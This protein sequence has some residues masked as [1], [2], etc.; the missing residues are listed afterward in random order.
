MFDFCFQLC[1]NV[2]N[3]KNKNRGMFMRDEIKNALE[4]IRSKVLM[5]L[6]AIDNEEVDSKY[7]LIIFREERGIIED[8]IDDIE[9]A[10]SI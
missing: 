4:E 2:F 3:K 8:M 6:E 5:V 10:L 1:Y 7:E 9:E